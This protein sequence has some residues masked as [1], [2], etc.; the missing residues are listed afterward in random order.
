MEMTKELTV[1]SV[2]DNIREGDEV[3]IL[4]LVTSVES[5]V[6]NVVSDQSST[7]YIIIVEDDSE[8]N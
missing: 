4:D 1:G 3:I 2:D 7:T 6:I 8:Y 5:N